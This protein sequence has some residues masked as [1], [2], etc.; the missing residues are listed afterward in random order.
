MLALDEQAKEAGI[1]VMNE[2]GVSKTNLV[3][4]IGL[5]NGCPA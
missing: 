5:F 2:I 1:T 4:L 3:S